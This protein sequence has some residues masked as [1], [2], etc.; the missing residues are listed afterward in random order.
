MRVSLDSNDFM[1]KMNN[2]LNYSLGFLDGANKGKSQFLKNL[3][4]ETIFALSEYID[5]TARMNPQS[6]HH[7]YEWYHTGSPQYRLF[8][9]DYTVSN[10]GLSIKST[11]KQSTSL[12]SGSFQPFY[13]KARIM[14]NGIPV[15]IK[16]KRSSALVF[17][18]GGE[19]VFTKSEIVN[20]FPGGKEVSGSYE[21]TFDEF[22]INYFKQSFL[23]ASGLLAYLNNPV[24]YKKNFKEGALRGRSAGI[25]AGYTWIA[26]ATVGVER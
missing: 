24:A 1:T 3:G 8:N 25:K 16:P 20:Q 6:L 17:E 21:K 4:K 26:N 5:A 9:L 23:R 10:L 14:E 13:D 2:I 7:V 18:D 15:S 22:F 11:F 19:V 12:A